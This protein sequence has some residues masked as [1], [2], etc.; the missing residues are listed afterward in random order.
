[1]KTTGDGFHAA[2]ATAHDALDAAVA[3][4]L[5]LAAE[6]WEATGLYRCGWVIHTGHA[7][8]RDGDYYGTAV[9]RA[10]RLMAAGHGG[11]IV[12]SP[13][14]RGAACGRVGVELLDLGEHVLR[15][16]GR[17]ERVFQVVHPGLAARVP[18][19]CARS[20]RSRGTCPRR[21]TSFVG[22]DDELAR[23]PTRSTMTRLVT[24]TGVGGVGKTRLAHPGRGVGAAIVPRRRMARASSP[25]RETMASRWYSV[26][27][28]TLRVCQSREGMSIGGDARASTCATKTLLVVF[29]NCEHL[30]ERGRPS[31][32]R[33]CLRALSRGANLGDES[34]GPR[35]RR[36]TCWALRALDAARTIR[37]RVERRSGR[38]GRSLFIDRA[39][40]VDPSLRARRVD[41]RGD[42]G[43]LSPPRR[44]SARHRTR[45]CSRR[46]DESR[47]RSLAHLDE[48]FR[49]LTG[50]R[51]SAIDRHQT[52]RATVD[53]SYSLLRGTEQLV[54]TRLGTFPNTFESAAAEAVATGGGIEGWD[55][56]DALS[57]LVD[58]SMLVA[59]AAPDASTRYSMLETLR[60][61]ARDRLDE[62]GD[63][64][65]KRRRHAQHYA[66]V[67]EELGP[68][69]HSVDELAWRARS[70]LRARQPARRGQLGPRFPHRRR[71]RPRAPHHRRLGLRTAHGRSDSCRRLGD[72]RRPPS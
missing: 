53:W 20:T 47:S 46:G 69:L 34:R 52:L 67:A 59:D 11:Q 49:L 10:A 29:D 36:R 64:D 70:A 7:E 3:A 43:D 65:A 2:F 22:R 14:D 5:A 58:K 8:L 25:A 44:D 39:R 12:V 72:T 40:A 54:F 30:L 19:A 24:V 55:V 31:R 15:D 13:G 33:A 41:R 60:S 17:A 57:S 1:M 9:N 37:R 16:L 21:S 61:Y 28:A 6:R 63:A 68:R 66:T 18:A 32:R 71:R 48:R 26:V 4:Q 56:L 45:R 27:A 42:R 62:T 38:R 23:S 51:R 50:G 35:C